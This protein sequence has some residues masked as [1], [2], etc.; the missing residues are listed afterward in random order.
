MVSFSRPGYGDT[1]VGALTAEEFAPVVREV[2]EQLHLDAVAAAVGVSFGGMQA[3]HVAADP[4]LRVERLVLHSCAPSVLP[5]PDTRAET[6]AGPLVFSP[7]L[8]GIVWWLIHRLVRSEAGLRLMMAPLSTIPVGEW[9]DQ[10]S[11]IDKTEA[12]GLF[13]SMQSGSGFVND[14]RQG[15]PGG[16]QDR[17]AALMRVACP[18]L[19]TGSRFDAGCAS[20]TPRTWPTPFR[21]PSWSSSTRRTTC[22]GS[23]HPETGLHRCSRHSS[24]D[25][26]RW[27]G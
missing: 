3:A 12:R 21:E 5:Y 20:R 18:T 13:Q 4:R 7:T 25:E 19:V 9:W 14:L 22:S 23:V 11:P 10:L 27:S 17:R 6:V 8:Q 1:R 2:C 16:T 15:R 24:A 26:I